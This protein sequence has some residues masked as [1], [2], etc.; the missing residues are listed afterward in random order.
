MT[1]TGRI[2]YAGDDT[3][4]S[5]P[6]HDTC[7]SFVPLYRS[8]ATVGIFLQLFFHKHKMQFFPTSYSKCLKIDFADFQNYSLLSI[9]CIAVKSS[10]QTKSQ[11]KSHSILRAKRA[12]CVYVSSGKKFVKNAKNDN[13]KT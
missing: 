3:R 13:L 10:P 9:F 2:T 7:L 12:K 4:L 11:K 5:L 8:N 6:L 1:Y